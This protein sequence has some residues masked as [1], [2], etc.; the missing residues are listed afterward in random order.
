MDCLEKKRMQVSWDCLNQMSRLQ[1]ETG[2]DIRLSTK[3]FS[4]CLAD[5]YKFCKD[6]QPGHM[7]VQ[8]RAGRAGRLG[9][10]PG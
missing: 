6:V 4:K 10:A 8:V 7:R 1:Q 2:D 9:R 3:L 5:S